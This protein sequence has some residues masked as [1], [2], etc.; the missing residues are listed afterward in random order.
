MVTLA[1][2]YQGLSLFVFIQRQEYIGVYQPES[3]GNRARRRHF[4]SLYIRQFNNKKTM[5]LHE[6]QV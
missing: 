3:Y 2:H 6:S 1:D 4:K 5:P